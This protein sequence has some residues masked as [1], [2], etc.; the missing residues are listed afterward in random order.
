MKKKK[1]K[2][3]ICDECQG[4][5]KCFFCGGTG[6]DLTKRKCKGCQPPGSGRCSK[7]AGSGQMLSK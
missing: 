2:T 4:T 3:E 1:S 5:G 6:L 7:C